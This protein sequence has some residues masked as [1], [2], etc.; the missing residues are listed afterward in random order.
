MCFV[1]VSCHR[2]HELYYPLKKII[3]IFIIIIFFNH[4]VIII[5]VILI[6]VISI[7]ILLNLF[8]YMCITITSSSSSYRRSILTQ[9]HNPSLL[10]SP[11]L[12]YPSLQSPFEKH[13]H[14]FKYDFISTANKNEGFFPHC[15]YILCH[16]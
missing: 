14:D 11:L 5:I 2:L 16:T 8:L 9:P 4:H 13:Q 12:C 6:I 3:I 7:I 1:L 10:S 15:S